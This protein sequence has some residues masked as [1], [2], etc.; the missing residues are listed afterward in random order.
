MLRRPCGNYNPHSASNIEH[1]HRLLEHH[2]APADD[3]T[4]PAVYPSIDPS[5][6]VVDE[7]IPAA[8]V[9]AAT[10]H[11]LV[12]NLYL[13]KKKFLLFRHMLGQGCA[14]KNI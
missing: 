7:L 6:R 8:L 12:F 3:P 1:A 4:L 2:E 14:P 5:D 9:V 11:Q 10:R 13:A